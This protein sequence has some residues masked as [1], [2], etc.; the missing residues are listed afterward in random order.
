VVETIPK[1]T[2]GN[3]LCRTSPKSFFKNY[4]K[5]GDKLTFLWYTIKYENVFLN[6]AEEFNNEKD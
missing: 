1:E 3:L 6:T 4:E 2:S 5:D